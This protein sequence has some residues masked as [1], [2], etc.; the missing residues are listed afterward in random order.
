MATKICSTCGVKKKSNEFF[1]G[2]N[3]CK[4][5]YT[6]Y[7]IKQRKSFNNNNKLKIYYSKINKKQTW[8]DRG[9]S[10]DEHINNLKNGQKRYNELN[11]EKISKQRAKCYKRKW[12]KRCMQEH[13]MTEQEAI[14]Q[15]EIMQVGRAATRQSTETKNEL[16]TLG[17][18]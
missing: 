10:Y 5:C 9:E 18:F 11:R 14:I 17:I 8:R 13:G 3:E 12:I 15:H 1:D 6:E 2:Q 4:H 7:W 16:M